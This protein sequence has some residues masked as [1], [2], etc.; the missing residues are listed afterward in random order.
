MELITA[1]AILF[2]IAVAVVFSPLGL[3]GGVLY[4]PIFHYILEWDF[5]E[6]VIGSLSLV[7]MVTLGS[8]LAHSKSGNAHEEAVK[9]GRI[10]AAPAA[11][12]GTLLSGFMIDFIGDISIKIIA[13]FILL[14]VVQ[15]TLKRMNTEEESHNI[16]EDISSLSKQY[17]AGT[18]MAGL[19]SGL[20]GIGGG[21]ILVTLNRNLLK[22]DANTSS[23][24]SYLI[25]STIVPI[26]LVSHL[27]LDDVNQNIIDNSGWIGII[28]VLS[29]VFS[30]AYF[31][32][33]YAIKNIS[34]NIVSKVF[35]A[36]VLLGI[37]RYVIDIGSK[38]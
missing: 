30:S 33:K 15:R 38:L 8:G 6:S 32:A 16:H 28:F 29:I 36:A 22:M 21:A 13:I 11:I 23:G 34:K 25:A 3:G 10:T 19:A 9:L 1:I 24:T 2:F 20:I 18:S 7:F 17:Q 26:A 4:V 27:L 5:L 12:V 37:I 31:G 35:L 14:F